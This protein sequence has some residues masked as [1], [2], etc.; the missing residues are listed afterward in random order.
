MR[1]NFFHLC[2]AGMALCLCF[3]ACN[4]ETEQEQEKPAVTL[5]QQ[6]ENWEKIEHAENKELRAS[7]ASGKAL[8]N[9]TGVGTDAPYYC[10]GEANLSNGKGNVESHLVCKDPVYDITYFVNYGRD[11]FIYAS[12]SGVSEVAVEIPAKDLFCREGELYFIVENY[13]TYILDGME[14]GNI[15]KYNPVDGTVEVVL[16]KNVSAMRVFPDVINCCVQIPMVID[17]KVNGVETSMEVEISVNYCYSFETGK[18]TPFVND[19]TIDRWRDKGIEELRMTLSENEMQGLSDKGFEGDWKKYSGWAVVDSTGER[20]V[21]LPNAEF[22]S[23]VYR[24]YGSCL[25]YVKSLEKEQR[26]ALMAFDCVTGEVKQMVKLDVPDDWL[27]YIDFVILDEVVYFGSSYRCSLRD[28]KLTMLKRSGE[29]RNVY[30]EALYTNGDEL[31]G[32][33]DGCLW[34]IQI[35]KEEEGKESMATVDGVPIVCGEYTYSL[36][37][38]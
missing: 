7:I 32:V 14:Q 26:Y 22:Y 10:N 16:D 19:T 29:E 2:C 15:L 28:G 25:Y 36:V 31:F 12:R 23:G 33:L 4:K 24:I 17:E 3:M 35:E 9:L 6:E 5:N 37:E 34:K 30:A 8:A 20:L 27:P 13:D 1:R 11:F 38:P 21:E 18:I